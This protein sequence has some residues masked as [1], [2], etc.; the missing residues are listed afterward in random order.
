MIR[1]PA[2]GWGRESA[3]VTA[4]RAAAA[5]GK[6]AVRT[7]ARTV[8]GTWLCVMGAVW[9]VGSLGSLASGSVAGFVGCGVGSVLFFGA[10]RRAFSGPREPAETAHAVQAAVAGA[11]GAACAIDYSRGKLVSYCAFGAVA[12]IAALWGT[13]HLTGASH[14]VAVILIPVFAA[15]IFGA[16]RK[17]CGDL[18]A[19]RWDSHGLTAAS[20]WSRRTAAWSQV[21]SVEVQEVS[22]YTA[23]G[24]LKVGSGRSLTIRFTD[25]GPRRLALPASML[26]LQGQTPEALALRLQAAQVGRGSEQPARRRPQPSAGFAPPQPRPRPTAGRA[27]VDPEAAVARYMAE[28]ARAQPAPPPAPLAPGPFHG[29]DPARATFGRRGV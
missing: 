1:K 23:Y 11:R 14:L 16:A 12:L 21:Q 24:L 22:T 27:S 20:L 15:M 2:E 29:A 28:Q 7:G 6:S 26:D 19:L 17:A 18:T 3:A 4:M 8:R 10:G 5:T 25:G 9:L 13:S